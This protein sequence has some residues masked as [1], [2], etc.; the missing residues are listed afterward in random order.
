MRSIT[1]QPEILN[2]TLGSR[3]A[4]LNRPQ[5]SCLVACFLARVVADG[6]DAA[7]NELLL[8]LFE[9]LEVRESQASPALRIMRPVPFAKR[10]QHL[11]YCRTE[12]EAARP[13][14]VTCQIVELIDQLVVKT[15]RHHSTT[16]SRNSTSHRID[17]HENNVYTDRLTIA[18]DL[19]PHRAGQLGRAP[20][21]IRSAPAALG[22]A[23]GAAPF[24]A[25][26]RTGSMRDERASSAA[27]SPCLQLLS[28]PRGGVAGGD[29]RY[30]SPNG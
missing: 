29:A 23:A 2:L 6:I 26:E 28:T 10:R 30:D 3:R 1:R 8:K 17:I 11:R 5:C 25:A 7:G 22:R 12:I 15:D 14:G 13:P 16:H 18:R 9:E 20:P 24:G 19:T 4:S 27:R 21:H